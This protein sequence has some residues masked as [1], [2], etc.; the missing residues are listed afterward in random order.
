MKQYMD[1]ALRFKQA[2]KQDEYYA[3]M[4]AAFKEYSEDLNDLMAKWGGKNYI[5]FLAGLYF[6]LQCMEKVLGQQGIN[7]ARNLAKD[8][9][10]VSMASWD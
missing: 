7:M 8:I 5:I 2:G 9:R 6:T 10:G 1:I 3:V 4:N